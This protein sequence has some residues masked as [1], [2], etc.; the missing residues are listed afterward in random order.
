VVESLIDHQ[1]VSSVPAGANAYLVFRDGDRVEGSTGCNTFH[2]TAAR[3]ADKIAFSG[4][5]ATKMACPAQVDRLDESAVLAVLDGEVTPHVQGD[6]LTLTH[7]G[8]RGLGLRAE[9]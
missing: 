4:I 8:G 2:G 1:T 3:R 5:V 9:P 6:R 7:P